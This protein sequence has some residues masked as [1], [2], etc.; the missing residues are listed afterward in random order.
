MHSKER[1]ASLS[2]RWKSEQRRGA[3]ARGWVATVGRDRDGPPP[4]SLNWDESITRLQMRVMPF[5]KK[6][7]IDSTAECGTTLN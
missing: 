2:P 4:V 3:P 7:I 5:K 6:G 1:P